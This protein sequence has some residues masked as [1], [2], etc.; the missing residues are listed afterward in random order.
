MNRR[1]LLKMIAA[2]TGTT[3]LGA[4]Q[5]LAYLPTPVG[6]NIFTDAD[7]AFLDEVAEVIIPA[8]DTPGAKQA[9]VGAFITVFVSD[10]YTKPQQDRFRAGMAQL[11]AEAQDSYGKSFDE[12]SADERREMLQAASVTARA[13]A[14]GEV[15]HWF[16]PIQQLVLFGFFTSELGATEVLRYDPVPGFYDGDLEYDGGPAWAT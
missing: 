6:E 8:T 13:Q 16:T 11:Q 12:M 15:P 7:A 10:C 3:M 4:Q 2:V 9:G 5:A 14:G 1:D